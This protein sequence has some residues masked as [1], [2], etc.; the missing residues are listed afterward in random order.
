VDEGHFIQKIL[1]PKITI[2]KPRN[3]KFIPYP[4]NKKMQKI[5]KTPSF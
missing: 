3:P 2:T 1:L 5:R 4:K